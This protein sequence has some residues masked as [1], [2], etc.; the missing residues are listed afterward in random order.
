[1]PTLNL[2]WPELWKNAPAEAEIYDQTNAKQK[3]FLAGSSEYTS[4]TTVAAAVLDGAA[5]TLLGGKRKT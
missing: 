3:F 4:G 1:M 2:T 5:G